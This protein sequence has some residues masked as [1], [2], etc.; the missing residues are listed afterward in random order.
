MGRAR[1]SSLVVLCLLGAVLGAFRLTLPRLLGVNPAFALDWRTIWQALRSQPVAFGTQDPSTIGGFFTPPWGVLL[2]RP[3][4]LL[5]M[6][7]GWALTATVTLLALVLYT[8]LFFPNTPQG[9]VLL[10]L[11]AHPT[12][13]VLADG[14]LE[15]FVLLGLT[16][17]LYGFHQERFWMGLLGLWLALVKPQLSWLVLLV[18]IWRFFALRPRWTARVLAGMSG[19]VI[20]SLLLWG[21]P[22]LQ[23]LFPQSLWTLTTVMGRG[24]LIDI[25]L[26]GTLQRLG[27]PWG[28]RIALWLLV[29]ALTA[30]YLRLLLPQPPSPRWPL[31]SLPA[32]AA[33]LLS[34]YVSGNGIFMML[35]FGVLPLWHHRPSWG[36]LG[37]LLL[38]LPYA[39]PAEVRFQWG[40]LYAFLLVLGF[41]FLSLV[42]THTRLRGQP[43][44]LGKA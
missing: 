27:V 13:R 3:L 43:T 30:F 23:A 17:L 4:A 20:V 7:D 31:G 22:W 29:L 14:N 10:V 39:M 26:P 6:V 35:P 15:G 1:A 12:L 41:W 42:H 38:Y 37:L 34:P 16:L 24:S 5:P 9:F 8:Y 21:K 19:V 11:L 32:S 36:W 2:L 44:A 40:S 25:S 18:W 33:L 28:I